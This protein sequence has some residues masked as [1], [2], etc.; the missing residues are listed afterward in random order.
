MATEFLCC[1]WYASYVAGRQISLSSLAGTAKVDRCSPSSIVF[2]VLVLCLLLALALLKCR[3]WCAE[4]RLLMALN[5]IWFSG[6]SRSYVNP[7]MVSMQMVFLV[8]LYLNSFYLT[9]STVKNFENQID[10]SWTF[11]RQSRWI[12]KQLCNAD[13][14]VIA[15]K[16]NILSTLTEYLEALV[17]NSDFWFQFLGSPLEAEFRF[18]FWFLRFRS[19]FFFEIRCWKIEKSEFRFQNS[20]FRRKK[21]NVGFNIPHLTQDINRNR[22]AGRPHDA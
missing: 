15:D 13:L 11:T 21:M 6:L 12:L 19:D 7:G 22:S 10:C 4:T 1:R 17:G 14:K 3:Q 20:V 18:R 16:F 5:W 2:V 9:R 8:N